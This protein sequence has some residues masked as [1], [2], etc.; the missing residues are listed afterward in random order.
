MLADTPE[1]TSFSQHQNIWV[2]LLDIIEESRQKELFEKITSGKS[3]TQCSFYYQFYLHQ[4]LKKTG[5]G[6]N[7]LEHLKPW[8]KMIELGLTTFAEKPEPARSDCHAWSAH[9]NFNLLAIVCGIESSAPAFKKV[10]ISPNL[11]SLNWVK[12]EMPH[13]G[14]IISVE[15]RK[16]DTEKLEAVISLPAGVTGTFNWKD[17]KTELKSGTQTLTF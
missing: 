9:P 7:Y 16:T 15:Y 10:E 5:F 14:G 4:A 8:H 17:K 13:P 2:I 12:A 1:K 3:I 11:G 6:D